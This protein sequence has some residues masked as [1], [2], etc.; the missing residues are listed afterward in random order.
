LTRQTLEKYQVL[1][2]LAAIGAGLAAGTFF[3]DRSAVLS[4]ILWPVLGLLLYTTFVQVP[5][6]HLRAAFTDVRFV[7]AAVSGN[8]G[9]MPIVVMGLLMFVPGDAAIR[10]GV[11]LVLLA[12]CTDWFITFTHLGGGDTKSALAF[13]P[14]SLL[15]Q[16]ALLPGYLWLLLG[17]EILVTAA[18]AEMLAAFAG[19]I[20]LPLAATFVTQ[21]WAE[22]SQVRGA[23]VACLAWF[24]VPLLALV[25]FSIAAAQV[26]VVAGSI[27]VLGNLLLVY[28]AYLILAGLLA[29]VLARQFRLPAAQGRAL[30]FSL[31]TRNSFVVLPLAI[32]LPASLEL[33]V[34]A[35]V[36]QS[37]VELFGMAGY[38][39]WIPK[40][41]FREAG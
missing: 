11:A 27:G 1:I 13:A 12:P 14:V 24:P 39:W 33:A 37:L 32:A 26:G 25:V 15:L 6:T 20:L 36:F 18:R 4:T 16:M 40:R 38:L 22:H 7:A 3:P 19:L 34:V 28:A 31:G 30:A 2:Y 41:L 35:I 8:F 23:H 10:L 9:L 5:L 17:Q 21:K 29:R